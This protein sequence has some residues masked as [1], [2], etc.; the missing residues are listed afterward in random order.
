MIDGSIGDIE[1]RV[2][3]IADDDQRRGGK[4]RRGRERQGRTPPRLGCAPVE[5]IA[6][7]LARRSVQVSLLAVWALAG[8]A[9]VGGVRGRGTRAG[10]P[11]A[12]A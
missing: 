6:R 3:R 4:R 2:R 5:A 12:T 10:F 1:E 7:L 8:L 11:V 9:V